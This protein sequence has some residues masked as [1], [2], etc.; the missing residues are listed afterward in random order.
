MNF[1]RPVL[2]VPDKAFS[3]TGVSLAL[4]VFEVLMMK[5]RIDKPMRNIAI[6]C[7]DN[8]AS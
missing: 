6:P 3:G 7:G 1:I 8:K 4:D 5:T 2:A